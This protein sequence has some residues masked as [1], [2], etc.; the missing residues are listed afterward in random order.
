MF[1][2][3]GSSLT[4]GQN[5]CGHCE[6][7]RDLRGQTLHKESSSFWLISIN[8]CS[9]KGKLQHP[10]H[11]LL[12]HSTLEVVRLIRTSKQPSGRRRDGG[13]HRITDRSSTSGK[14]IRAKYSWQL[15]E[16]LFAFLFGWKLQRVCVCVCKSWAPSE[17]THN[18]QSYISVSSGEFHLSCRVYNYILLQW[19]HWLNAA[20][21][22]LHH[23]H[24]LL[25]QRNDAWPHLVLRRVHVHYHLRWAW[26]WQERVLCYDNI[27]WVYSVVLQGQ[28]GWSEVSVYWSCSGRILSNC[29]GCDVSRWCH[30]HQMD[31]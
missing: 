26:K 18:I 28:Q 25:T 6:T 23:G 3:S 27:Q 11:P 16:K 2:H 31:I 15:Y 8:S 4:A 9:S 20:S 13:S 21:P 30:S 14:Q 22:G 24:Y 29:Q 19:P 17:L 1:L 12:S 7:F 5:L 10:Q